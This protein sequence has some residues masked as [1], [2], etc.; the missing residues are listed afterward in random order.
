MMHRIS[1][2]SV[3]RILMKLRCRYRKFLL[4]LSRSRI[5][6]SSVILTLTK[7]QRRY[8][9][10]ILG[11]WHSRISP[12]LVIPIETKL[13]HRYRKFLPGPSHSHISPSSD[14]QMLLKYGAGTGNSDR[15]HHKINSGWLSSKMTIYFVLPKIIRHKIRHWVF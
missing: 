5:S 13:W 14:I 11:L 6:P 10:F 4:G 3:I 12:S 1:S 7:L 2:S 15:D 9:K 8:N